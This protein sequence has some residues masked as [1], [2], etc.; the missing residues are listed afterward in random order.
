MMKLLAVVVFGFVALAGS[1]AREYFYKLILTTYRNNIHLDRN[2]I[3]LIYLYKIRIKNVYN[4]LCFL[5]FIE[6]NECF[7]QKKK[8]K[9]ILINSL[10]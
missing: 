6:N 2:K 5:D 3:N 10:L 4:K 9:N 8:N 7:S 1:E